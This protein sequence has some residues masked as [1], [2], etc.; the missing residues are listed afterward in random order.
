MLAAYMDVRGRE[1]TRFTITST[2]VEPMISAFFMMETPSDDV[3]LCNYEK[4]ISAE[5]P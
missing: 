3:R 1:S 4:I 2:T 5:V